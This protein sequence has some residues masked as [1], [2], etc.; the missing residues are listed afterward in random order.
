MS[1]SSS[2]SSSSSSIVVAAAAVVIV[3]VVYI[4][5]LLDSVTPGGAYDVGGASPVCLEV[6]KFVALC[7][8]LATATAVA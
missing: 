3:I 5:N 7:G 1:R 6:T 8:G 2:S 4:I